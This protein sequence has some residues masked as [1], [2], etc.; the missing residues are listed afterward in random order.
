M[1]K[2][3]IPEDIKSIVEGLF[4]KIARRHKVKRP[5]NFLSEEFDIEVYGVRQWTVRGIP[6]MHRERFAQL[7]GVS[8]KELQRLHGVDG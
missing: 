7:A 8:L 6:P 5:E 4:D 1:K 3:Y 2:R